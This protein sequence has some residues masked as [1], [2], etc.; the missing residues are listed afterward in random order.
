MLYNYLE[1]FTSRYS[2]YDGYWF[3][4]LLFHQ[5]DGFSIELVSSISMPRDDL[6]TIWFCAEARS[7]FAEL[8]ERERIPPEFVRNASL[9]S[10]LLSAEVIGSIAGRPVAGSVFRLT[11]L[12]TSDL[13]VDYRREKDLF[14][15]PHDST[16]EHRSI[17]RRPNQSE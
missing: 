5:L 1:T 7:R 12:V 8:I 14:V 15:A 10:R 6:V 9:A 16:R 11:T 4:G 17:R 3:F 2:D 13:G